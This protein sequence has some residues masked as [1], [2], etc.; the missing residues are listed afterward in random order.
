MANPSRALWIRHTI[1]ISRVN[2]S[3]SHSTVVELNKRFKL[4]VIVTKI[5]FE[6][7][8]IPNFR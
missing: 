7:E 6:I 3:I 5:D 2:D 1:V 4:N 8:V